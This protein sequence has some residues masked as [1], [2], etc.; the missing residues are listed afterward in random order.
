[1]VKFL[2]TRNRV[3][4]HENGKKM[5]KGQTRKIGGVKSNVAW[6]V[7]AYGLAKYQAHGFYANWYFIRNPL[8]PGRN[9][10]PLS[11]AMSRAIVRQPGNYGPRARR[12]CASFKGPYFADPDG[13]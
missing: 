11:G 5:V 12:R 4:A 2:K 6:T 8:G 1:M 10:D 9:L 3:T 13:I 7:G